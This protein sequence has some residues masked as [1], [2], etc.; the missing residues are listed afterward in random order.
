MAG[1]CTAVFSDSGF[2]REVLQSE[3][4]VLVD[5]WA[6]WRPPCRQ[7]APTIYAVACEYADRAK[8]GKLDIRSNPGA[9]V[10]YRVRSIPTRVLF[11]SGQVVEQRVGALSGAEVRKM[12]D[13]HW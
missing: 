12:I 11:Q 7:I 4:P 5:F 2:D 1:A 8:V 9:T 13:P 3:V 6:E 10:R